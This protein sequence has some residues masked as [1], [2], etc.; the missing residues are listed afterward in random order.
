MVTIKSPHKKVITALSGFKE[1]LKQQNVIGLA[2]GLVLGSSSKGVVDSLVADI[3]NPI[4]GM[5][6]GGIE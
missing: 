6:M 1:F 4:L 2:I 3:F 5:L